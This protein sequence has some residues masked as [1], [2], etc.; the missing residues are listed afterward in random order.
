MNASGATNYYM[1]LLLEN[2]RQYLNEEVKFSGIL[3]LMPEPGVIAQAKN[4]I[5]TLPPEAVPLGD[6]RLHVTLIHQSILKPFKKQLKIMSKAGELPLAPPVVLVSD[7]E[8]RED[9]EAARKSWVVWAEN[10]DELAAYVNQVMG[11]VGGPLNP[12]PE[13]RYHISLANL[14]GNPGDSVR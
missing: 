2:W 7:W 10:Q 8:E 9:P 6:D 13:R 14:T 11:L 5:E 4:L 1:K 12:E 3:K